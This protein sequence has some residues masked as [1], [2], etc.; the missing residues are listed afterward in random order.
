MGA[1]EYGFCID[2]R[3]GLDMEVYPSGV[4]VCAFELGLQPFEAVPCVCV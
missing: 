4:L 2:I 3:G 1:W